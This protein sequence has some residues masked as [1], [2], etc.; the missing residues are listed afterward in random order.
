MVEIEDENSEEGCGSGVVSGIGSG[1]GIDGTAEE[2]SEIC[3]SEIDPDV[4]TG[5]GTEMGAEV[6]I[7]LLD[8]GTVSEVASRVEIKALDD[9]CTEVASIVEDG[10]D[11]TKVLSIGLSRAGLEVGNS[12][13]FDIPGTGALLLCPG[14]STGAELVAGNGTSVIEIEVELG[15]SVKIAEEEPSSA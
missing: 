11:A 3:G 1:S 2:T 10:G 6:S 5:S 14:T 8:V 13:P 4:D 9:T 12:A 7:R 15:C